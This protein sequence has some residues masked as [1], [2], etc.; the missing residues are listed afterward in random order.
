MPRFLPVLL[1]PCLTIAA[2]ARAGGGPINVVVLFNGDDPDSE[3]VATYYA[4]QRSLPGGH[5]CGIAGIDPDEQEIA[6]GDFWTL[7]H[8]PLVS[9][10]AS[11][12]HAA[13]VDYLV[14]V[15]GL[16]YRV[17]LDDD[18]FYTSLSAMLQVHEAGHWVTGDLLAGEPQVSNG[19]FTAS[20]HN[21][22]FVEG[23]C[24]PGDLTVENDSSGWYTSA[25][26]IVRAQAHPSSFRR[27]ELGETVPWAFEGNLFVVTRLDGF[28]HDDALDLIDRGVAADG[29][30][31]DAEILCMAAAEDARGARDPECEFVTRHLGLAGFPGSWLTPHDD[32]LAGHELAAYFTGAA[33]LTA[34]IAGNTFVPGAIACNMTSFG[35]VPA[36]FFCDA[37]GTTC[38]E[39]E[40]QTSIA[41]FVRAGATGAHGTV[42]EPL[43]NSFPSAGALLYYGFGYNLGESFLFAQRF[44]YWQ[45][46]LLGDP[47]TTPYAER[48]TVTFTEGLVDPGSTLEVEADHPDGV[49]ALRLYVDGELVA[50]AAGATLQWEVTAEAGSELDLLAV[51]VADNGPVYLPNWPEEQH[52]PRPDVQGW[53]RGS[54]TVG[55]EAPSDDDD[56]AGDDDDADD[57][58]MDDDD[59]AGGCDCRL[60]SGS[61][62]RGPALLVL[63]VLLVG[64]L[65]PRR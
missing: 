58:A 27:S 12:P 11:L 60:A 47:L 30:Y 29:S 36:N 18:G 20:V 59:E 19:Y 46:L 2:V 13:D 45:N 32:A 21:P 54:V 7:V 4:Q 26:G 34:A 15:R 37:T 57:D 24:L 62:V 23:Q 53:L 51:A 33:D 55:G 48:P 14:V 5:L 31:P 52:L 63:L 43:N 41:R 1:L 42:A 35:A 40:S 50:E 3:M 8:Q 22:V 64:R 16:P 65:R 28:D 44:L 10:L 38:P 49:A 56:S 61:P 25:C 9:C 39:S 6:F 17:V